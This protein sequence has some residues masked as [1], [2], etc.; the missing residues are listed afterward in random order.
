MS[1]PR[2]PFPC[3]ARTSCNGRILH[4]PPVPPWIALESS[5]LA[6]VQMFDPRFGALVQMFDPDFSVRWRS[7]HFVPDG[8]RRMV[9]LI[10]EKGGEA[11]DLH[12]SVSSVIDGWGS[13]IR[14]ID[15]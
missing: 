3:A 11:P 15:V 9:R 8:S 10:A 1:D 4:S 12:I 7:G 2:Y 14:G 13:E 6:N 5:G